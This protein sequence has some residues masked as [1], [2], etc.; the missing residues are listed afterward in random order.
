MDIFKF[1]DSAVS[2]YAKYLESFINILDPQIQEVV[3]ESFRRGDPFPPA[4]LQLN[5]FFKEGG[6]IDDLVSE[7]ILHPECAKIFRRKKHAD[8]PGQPLSLYEHQVKGIRA[9]HAGKNYVLTTGTGSGKSLAYIIPIV[10]H[11]LR[12]GSGNGIQAIIVYPMNA[13]VNSQ[14]EELKKFINWG[15][16]EGGGPVTFRRYTGQESHEER[17]EIVARPPDIILTNYVMLELILTRVFERALVRKARGM[18]FLVLDE[19]H[20]Y[21]GRQG[22]DVALLIRRLRENVSSPGLQIIG[23]SATLAGAGSL[24]D[25][26]TSV[27]HITTR[28]FGSPVEPDVVIGETLE[29]I[30]PD[31]APEPAPLADSVKQAGKNAGRSYEDFIHDPLVIWLE[32]TI[33]LQRDQKSTEWI[34]ALP[35]PIEGQGSPAEILASLTGLPEE[36]C[37]RAIKM[38]LLEGTRVLDAKER[39]LFAF[40]FHQFL[41]RCDAVFSSLDRGEDRYVTVFPQKFVPGD[42]ER[43]LFPLAFCRECGEA[44]Y[45]VSRCGEDEQVFYEPR[46]FNKRAEGE[47]AEAGYLY[48][49]FEEK[50]PEGDLEKIIELLP[51]TML[52]E[53]GGRIQ[54]RQSARGKVPRVVYLSPLGEGGKG[55][56]RYLW[57]PTPFIFCHHCGVAYHHRQTSDFGKLTTLG[58]QGRATA[59]TIL[60]QAV[61]SR[62]RAD[63]ALPEEARKLLSFTDNRQDASLQAGHFN[64]F[65][66]VSMLRAALCGALE[67][68]GEQGLHHDELTQKVFGALALP[69]AAY[70]QN[71]HAAFAR[72][73]GDRVFRDVLGYHLYRDLR[74]GWRVIAPNLEQC[75]LLTIEYEHLSDLC[76]D[77]SCW[78]E[79]H[80]LLA[81]AAPETRLTIARVLLDYIRRE[82]GI[83]VDY[84][85]PFYQERISASSRQELNETWSMDERERLLHQGIIFSRSRWPGADRNGI[86]ISSR[87][88]FGQFLKRPN[89]FPGTEKPSTA[90]TESVIND[91][92]SVLHKLGGIVTE[93]TA[94]QERGYRLLASAMIWKAADGTRAFHD[95]IRMP[96]QP[97][98]GLRTNEFFVEFYRTAAR[99][100]VGLKAREHTA[101]V[102]MEDRQ[103]RER[104]F[105]SADLPVLFCSPTMELGVDIAD[106]NVVNL[107]NVPPTPANYAQRSGR[108]GR[109]GQPAFIY[110]YCATGSPHDSYFFKRPEKMVA[111]AV[112]PP[113]VELSNEDLVKSHI[114]AIWLSGTDLDLGKTLCDILDVSGDDPTL[115]FKPHVR[116]ALYSPEFR[117]RARDKATAFIGTIGEYLKAADWY[118]DDWLDHVLDGIPIEFESATRRWKGLYR[119]NR[120][121]IR[122]QHQIANDHGRSPEDQRRARDLRNLAERQLRLLTEAGGVMQSDFYPYRYFASEGFLP[123]YNFPRLPVSA[124]IPGRRMAGDEGNYI[125]R[126]RFL[127]VS[128][129][130]PR[131]HIYHEGARYEI[132]RVT[133]PAATDEETEEGSLF[134]AAKVCDEC[135]YLHPAIGG[136]LPDNCESCGIF[137]PAAD[138]NL[139]RMQNVS[140]RRRDR[141]NCDEE[142]RFRLGYDVWCA[143][144]F[145]DFGGVRS[146]QLATVKEGD[147]DL[148]E[149]E[150]GQ[151]ATIWR[152]NR[153]WKAND[154]PGFLLD[155]E[156]GLWASESNMPADDDDGE[157]LTN[158]LARV[159]PYAEDRKNALILRPV[160][161]GLPSQGLMASLQAAIKSAIQ[162]VFQLE[163][164]EIA[165][166]PLP[167][168]DDRRRVLFYE[169]SE[170]GAGAL[171]RLV[172]ERELFAEVARKALEI[173]HFD[174]DT[175]EDKRRAPQARE[176]CEA[177]CY[178]CLLSYSNQRDHDLID[179]QLLKDLLLAWSR[180]KTEVSSSP[181]SRAEH[182]ADLKNACDSSLEK[183]WLDR[184]HGLNLRLPT[185]AQ[186]PIPE[187]GTKP[188]FYYEEQRLVVYIDGPPHDYPDR[189]DR[190]KEQMN[191]LEDR[192]YWVM[193]FHHQDDWDAI[194]R[195]HP[196]IFGEM[197]DA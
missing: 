123:G 25:Q 192:G 41:S 57:F 170:G 118:T 153:G 145:A 8:D 91:L 96:R 155:L 92:L 160:Q 86:F 156:K 67:E 88:G 48:P 181:R 125:S 24:E 35:K 154:R 13:L 15:Y 157:A 2:D 17:D 119:S 44:Y 182:L 3:D 141:I 185:A 63:T 159:I 68:A 151:A 5:P 65:I 83:E 129:F 40:R 73:R 23:T 140:T 36:D 134:G 58:P 165:A 164:N 117:H 177:G 101:Q 32:N 187:C 122:I 60:A 70:L 94:G 197:S 1:R 144:R 143:I 188:D 75:G 121:Q 102:D 171:R 12:N 33:G 158:N 61:V 82:L 53:Q 78:K 111:G 148:A 184:V 114:H 51:E 46:E 193:R 39:P 179:R 128:E 108:A 109:G 52:D 38:T 74:K 71:P 47:E 50:W 81:A 189:Q 196:E 42:R 127:A 186:T 183:E 149:L 89:T 166:E 76:H 190:D 142:E 98:E 104:E 195:E 113:R 56:L 10:D 7:G 191:A 130:G 103:K 93:V 87:S 178:D 16:P 175:G 152:I 49:D 26:R 168:R 20:T 112:S 147:K 133:L 66:Q 138:N 176:D 163:D 126:P 43:R 22:A 21:R 14:L 77:E 110:T 90:D 28:F 105:R 69:P 139:M 174:P 37:A 30:T 62:L 172:D 116:D 162:V 18:Q 106:L 79:T 64:D 136:H 4:L 99:H 9:A 31:S 19:L 150:Y 34:R 95:P 54:I 120:N 100:L 169:A 27:A 124:Y 80:P 135:G 45:S 55:S 29:R 11:I 146:R 115:D 131:A 194:F 180:G 173:C 137:L 6:K 161:Q 167:S 107:R 84:L 85:S 132:N 59:T 97:E 72:D